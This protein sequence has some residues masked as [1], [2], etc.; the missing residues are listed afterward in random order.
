MRRVPCRNS[1]RRQRQQQRSTEAVRSDLPMAADRFLPSHPM[2]CFFSP[3]RFFV[4]ID[5]WGD[6]DSYRVV[7]FV[8]T[9]DFDDNGG[10]VS[11]IVTSKQKKENG[12]TPCKAVS[13]EFKSQVQ[14]IPCGIR[15]LKHQMSKTFFGI[16][17][18]PGCSAL[19]DCR[20]FMQPQWISQGSLDLNWS[21]LGQTKFSNGLF[22]RV[23]LKCEFYFV[24]NRKSFTFLDI[25]MLNSC[26]HFVPHN[27]IILSELWMKF[28]KLQ[29]C[30]L[31]NSHSRFLTF[32]SCS[33]VIQGHFKAYQVKL[34]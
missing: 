17:S 2:I 30:A 31:L 3:P 33:T 4:C 11:T 6:C 10:A 29:P 25:L 19:A 22:L 14:L 15:V 28:T 16:C 34:S 24:Q 13:H 18:V 9:D 26:V 5:K 1:A 27:E 23:L 21:V 8:K 20:L 7:C 32:L 12:K